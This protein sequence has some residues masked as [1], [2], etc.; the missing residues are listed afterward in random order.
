[1]EIED[2][3]YPPHK[4]TAPRLLARLTPAIAGK[5][6]HVLWLEEKDPVTAFAKMYE[7]LQT[8]PYN[9]AVWA[10]AGDMI[11]PSG[12]SLLSEWRKH[13]SIQ[14]PPH[15]TRS[16]IKKELMD[17]LDD[18]SLTYNMKQHLFSYFNK[19]S[20]YNEGTP[21]IDPVLNI[22]QDILL[23]NLVAMR[24]SIPFK[25]IIM[26]VRGNIVTRHNFYNDHSDGHGNEENLKTTLRVLQSIACPSTCLV[27]N[28]Y[29]TGKSS[30]VY[31][32]LEGRDAWETHYTTDPEK[33]VTLWKTPEN[34][35]VLITDDF[36]HSQPIVHDEAVLPA[37][38]TPV[39]RTVTV[40]DLV[41]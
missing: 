20:G 41:L 11:D 5:L 10:N 27:A 17:H 21:Q 19:L 28:K 35:V 22:V 4:D 38:K 13:N 25:N 16:A 8:P 15:S 39:P 40:C 14:Q 34:S 6:G 2:E 30:Y 1:M 31:P 32:Y 36:H 37:G 24:E 9:C 3:E 33:P 29:T 7:A 12:L 26:S 18:V 23:N